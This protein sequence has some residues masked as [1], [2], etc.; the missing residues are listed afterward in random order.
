V[1]AKNKP[2]LQKVRKDVARIHEVLM[3][4]WDPIGV[5][6]FPEAASEYD[7]YAGGVYSM[8]VNKRASA[9]SIAAYLTDVAV[10][11][12]GMTRLRESQRSKRVALILV[13]LRRE[14]ETD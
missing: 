5:K 13:G 7:A 8:M 10:N 1:P 14:F 11:R 9:A 3:R 2:R 12:M 4:E 6:D